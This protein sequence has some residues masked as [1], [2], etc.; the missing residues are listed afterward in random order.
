[1]ATVD[2]WTLAGAS[3]ADLTRFARDLPDSLPNSLEQFLPN[4][5]IQGIKTQ[6]VKTTRRRLVAKYRTWNTET[7]IGER[8]IAVTV[9]EVM[10]P[11]LGQML[12]LTEWES[13]LVELAKTGGTVSPALAEDIVDQVYDDITHNREATLNRVEVA[14]ADFLIDGK[15]TLTAENGLTMEYDAGLAASHT[16]PPGTVWSSGAATPLSDEITMN[17]LVTRESQSGP[18]TWALTDSDTIDF[19]R[20]NAEYRMAYWPSLPA[21]QAPRLGL[22]QMNDIRR[23]ENLPQLYAYDHQLEIDGVSTKLI[24]PGRFIFGTNGVGETQFGYTA[25]MLS[26]LSSNAIDLGRNEAPGLT[27][28]A[29]KRPN[30][31]TGYTQVTATSMPVG[32]DIGGLYSTVVR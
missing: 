25:E 17:R 6:T 21:G 7:P 9:D 23:R 22:D 16:T 2:L 30:P 13:I 28:V 20:N 24:P 5:T 14:R 11:P 29:W 18:V 15:F 32:G 1:M 10:L 3:P 27:A 19:L 12:M 8:P 4:R 31:F 26:L